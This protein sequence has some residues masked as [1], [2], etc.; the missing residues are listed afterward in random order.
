VASP[1]K[2]AM[3]IQR[4]GSSIE[5]PTKAGWTRLSPISITAAPN[6]NRPIAAA[7]WPWT[8]ST[9]LATPN[10]AHAPN[11]SMAKIIVAIVNRI[12]RGT[13]VAA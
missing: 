9:T 7:T 1:P 2:L 12:G 11:G 8:S 13:P 5:L 10:A 3:K 4:K 6:T